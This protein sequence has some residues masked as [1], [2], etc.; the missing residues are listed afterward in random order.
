MQKQ[1][2]HGMGI[3]TSVYIIY[4]TINDVN[5]KKSN[6]NAWFCKV[7]LVTIFNIWILKRVARDSGLPVCKAP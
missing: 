3:I 2:D 1:K 7:A 6:K 4:E 5:L